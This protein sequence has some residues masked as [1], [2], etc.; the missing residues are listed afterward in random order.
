MARRL[1]DPCILAA[2]LS[3]SLHA[4]QGQPEQITECLGYATEILRLAEET[5]EREMALEFFGLDAAGCRSLLGRFR[6]ATVFSREMSLTIAGTKRLGT[7]MT[8]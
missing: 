7:T 1:A 8:V 5:G 2:V 6:S 3:F 4:F